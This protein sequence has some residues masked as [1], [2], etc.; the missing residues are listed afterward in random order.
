MIENNRT[1]VTYGG[2]TE[3]LPRAIA[4]EV[5]EET[6]GYLVHS[7]RDGLWRVIDGTPQSV[8]SIVTGFRD[9]N[10]YGVDLFDVTEEQW[11][12]A[13]WDESQL[14]GFTS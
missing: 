10:A 13:N 9:A 11:A 5:H 8:A 7:G 14:P 6:G 2:V 1:V 4:A 12:A 3:P